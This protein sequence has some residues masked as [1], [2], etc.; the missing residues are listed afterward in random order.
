MDAANLPMSVTARSLGTEGWSADVL[1]AV[2]LLHLEPCTNNAVR[3]YRSMIPIPVQEALY[4]V[5][6]SAAHAAGEK[7]RRFS[8]VPSVAFV[9]R[10]D[11]ELAQALV[12]LE[13]LATKVLN[14]DDQVKMCA[15][16][17]HAMTPRDLGRAYVSITKDSIVQNDL[18]H[19]A[20]YM[21]GME[22]T[23][24]DALARSSGFQFCPVCADGVAVRA[25]SGC[26][27]VAY[28]SK[29][30]GAK[31]WRKHRRKCKAMKELT[32]AVR[33]HLCV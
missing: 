13:N 21:V 33:G 24:T 3:L 10:S 22:D 2:R 4:A 27:T 25:C 19:T 20:A 8:A 30:C 29:A 15:E 31:A 1:G 26:W 17:I 7:S 14:A 23:S 6:R 32:S 18:Y 28:C 5:A 16:E 12:N 11:R 9:F